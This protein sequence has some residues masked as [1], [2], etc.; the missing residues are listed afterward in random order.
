MKELLEMMARA[1][2]DSP[3]EVS[4][5]E[6]DEGET[7]TF[8]ITVAEPD[9]GKIIGKEGKVANAIRAIIK[10][11]AIRLRLEKKVLVKIG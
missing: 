4:I 8:K 7:L 1:L 2:V 3:D 10:A 9:M 11:A 6:V 5:E